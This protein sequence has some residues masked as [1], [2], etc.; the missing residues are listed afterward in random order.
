[1]QRPELLFGAILYLLSHTY[2][3]GKEGREVTGNP[4]TIP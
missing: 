2:E 4:G 1:M 3:L